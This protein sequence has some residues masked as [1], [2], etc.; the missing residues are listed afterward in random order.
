MK[1]I[2]QFHF[3]DLFKFLKALGIDV[4]NLIL[5]F[6]GSHFQC[7]KILNNPTSFG[8]KIDNKINNLEN[9]LYDVCK[10]NRMYQKIIHYLDFKNSK[11]IQYLI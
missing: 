1:K 7:N 9:S 3:L 8:N 6:T 2:N 10:K 5:N 11:F 4:E